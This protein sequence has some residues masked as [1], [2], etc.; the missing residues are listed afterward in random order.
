[1]SLAFLTS[2]VYVVLLLSRKRTAWKQ[3]RVQHCFSVK[4]IV[5]EEKVQFFW[6]KFITRE[7]LLAIIVTAVKI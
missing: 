1:M 2:L 4:L 3:F 7:L 6:V 5:F